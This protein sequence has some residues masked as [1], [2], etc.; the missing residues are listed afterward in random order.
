MVAPVAAIALFSLLPAAASAATVPI[1]GFV[2]LAVT[3]QPPVIVLDSSGNLTTGAGAAHL[4]ISVSSPQ[5]IVAGAP[6]P[7]P[8]LGSLTLTG[9]T[10]VGAA[11]TSGS[12]I[13]QNLSSGRFDIFDASSTLLLTGSVTNA[14]IVANSVVPNGSVL[15]GTFNYDGGSLFALFPAAGLYNPG[16]FSFSLTSVTP[17]GHIDAGTGQLAAFGAAASGTFDANNAVPLPAVAGM[18]LTLL[19]GVGGARGLRIFRRSRAVLAA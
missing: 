9:F 3:G 18:G 5:L 6:G 2:P 19:G 1:V 12:D 17:V 14:H 8:F 10:E 7:L 15:S 11:T 16:D 13:M 4:A